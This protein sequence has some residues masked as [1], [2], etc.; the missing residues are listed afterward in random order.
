MMSAVSPSN[1]IT[2]SGTFRALSRAGAPMRRRFG[3]VSVLLIERPVDLVL[4]F[5]RQVV[6]VGNHERLARHRDVAREALARRGEHR[7]LERVD[8]DRVV[9]GELPTQDFVIL[10]LVEQVERSR[11]RTRELAGLAQ[12]H[13]QQHGMVAHGRQR[14]AD[15]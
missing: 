1:G 4:R 9:L 11:I 15:L 12:N 6:R 13:R 14:C 2:F 5:G 8:V 7:F 10:Q 3:Q